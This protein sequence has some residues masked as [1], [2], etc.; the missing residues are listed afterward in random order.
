MVL[1][2]LIHIKNTMDCDPGLPPLVPRGR[3]R[4]LRDEHRRAQ[5]AG[6]HPRL[7]GGAG[8]G[9]ADRAA[10]QPAGGQGPDPGP[11][12][13]LRPVRL[14]R[15]LAA[16]QDAASRRPNGASRRRTA[17]QARRPL[18]VHP[19][20]LLLDLVPELLVER[21]AVPRPRHPAAAP[22][23]GSSTAATRPPA[24]GSMRWKTRSSSTAATP[25]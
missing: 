9:G 11:D 24:S 21:G 3:L 19:L 12:A 4:L 16:H 5:H 17:S 1:D 18:R 6:L 10:A 2:V 13:V 20:R 25:S 8:R 15:A 22:T 14:D 23:A 7:G